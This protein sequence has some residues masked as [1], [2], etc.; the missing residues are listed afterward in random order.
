MYNKP[1]LVP[2]L[3]QI[4]NSPVNQDRGVSSALTSKE[5]KVSKLRSYFSEVTA[6]TTDSFIGKIAFQG[7]EL[8]V[9]Q[10]ATSRLLKDYFSRLGYDDLR[11]LRIA[12]FVK[13]CY[14]WAKEHEEAIL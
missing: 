13:G 5:T 14:R 4:N 3:G 1:S 9:S 2:E 11:P 6:T 8:G 7:R 10:E 12:R